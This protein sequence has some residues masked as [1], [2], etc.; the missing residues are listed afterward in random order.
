MKI[1][2]N[3]ASGLI[4][5]SLA[6]FA[7]PCWAGPVTSASLFEPSDTSVSTTTTS[8]TQIAFGD[9]AEEHAER[10]EKM[11]RAKRKAERMTHSDADEEH[12]GLR[13]RIR[14]HV[15]GTEEHQL[16]EEREGEEH[17]APHAPAY[18]Y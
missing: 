9:D 12:G 4:G 10:H 2:R 6:A 16:H 11:E 17:H 3:L 13:N 5:L 1:G 14:E 7:V 8:G 18:G 15:P